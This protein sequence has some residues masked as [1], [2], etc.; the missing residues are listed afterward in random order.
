VKTSFN[1]RAAAIP[2]LA[3]AL[4]AAGCPTSDGSC[5]SSAICE[6]GTFCFDG[7]CVAEL[8]ANPSCTPPKL[9]AVGTG[10]ISGA[11]PSCNPADSATW[12]RPVLPVATGWEQHLGILS[13]H[14]VVPFVVPP[15][16]ASVAIHAQGV[17]AA[18]NVTIDYSLYWNVVAPVRVVLPNGQALLEMPEA[19]APPPDPSLLAGYSF[20]NSW[21]TTFA[22]PL[23]QR[24]TDLSLASGAVPAGTWRLTIGDLAS[25]CSAYGNCSAS[26]S[27]RYDVTVIAKPGPMLSAG[28]LAVAIYLVGGT[29]NAAQAAADAGYQRFVSGI[30]RVLGRAGICV[31]DVTFFDLRGV[32]PTTTPSYLDGG[33]CGDLQQLFAL[34]R[35]AVP[36]IDGVHLF[37]VAD[38]LPRSST[39]QMVV[40]MDG[41]IPGPSG[42]TGAT[43]SG[44]AMIMAN[45]GQ[46][47]CGTQFDIPSCGSDDA[48]YVA[49]HEIGHWL[50]LF[51]TTE[52]TGDQFDPLTD[53]RKCQC[54]SC[55]PASERA[56][57]SYPVPDYATLLYPSSCSSSGPDCA[58]ADNLMFWI[59]DPTNP[60]PSVGKFSWQ[61]GVVARSNPA[62][63]W[64]AP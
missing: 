40:G 2:L 8:P 5:E 56:M 15:G 58:G 35:F 6:A 17:D 25:E 12:P 32:A 36:R 1:P 44:A 42:L 22:A 39:G 46:G 34:S 48:A 11:L 28:T 10:T 41:S 45:I 3:L 9:G 20:P 49:S 14:E 24:F 38:L 57:C 60:D 29:M 23:T 47:T 26:T 59:Y 33:P 54:E 55:A 50:G 18:E 51:H 16:T 53:T 31:G 30:S 21:T 4:A 19:F 43:T 37:L 27:G 13:A 64:S 52:G 63:K 62:V 61:Q 7:R